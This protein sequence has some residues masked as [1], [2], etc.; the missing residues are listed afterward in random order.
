MGGPPPPR[1]VPRTDPFYLRPEARRY[2][3]GLV[4]GETPLM[5]RVAEE[6][7][8]EGLPAVARDTGALLRVLAA[9]ARAERILEVGLLLG[10]S[11]L[12]L[13]SGARPTARLETIEMD[14][15]FAERARRNFV[16]AGVANR[17]TIHQGVAGDVL[18]SLDGPYDVVFIDADKEGYPTY[19]DEALRLTRAEGLILADNAL[20]GGSVWDGAAKDEATEAIREYTRRACD[21]PRLRTV[22]LPV[23]DGLAVSVVTP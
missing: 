17:V 14:E 16:D 18:P 11:A 15:A 6:C 9:A 21:H 12:W 10:Y 5:R 7:S 19:L 8:R 22:V 1:H 20:W 2:L 4:S 3:S 13:L 23:G